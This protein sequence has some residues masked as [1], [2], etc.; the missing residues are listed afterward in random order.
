MMMPGRK[1]QAGSSS[2]R[3]GFNGQEKSNDVTQGNYTAEYWEY[4][5]RIGRRW[6]V[7]PKPNV[8]ISPYNCFEGNPI[9]FA[10]P[11]G[12]KPFDWI[13]KNNSQG[14]TEYKWDDKAKSPGTTPVGYTYVGATGSYANNNN[15]SVNLYANGGWF[16]SSGVTAESGSK[17][18][19]PPIQEAPSAASSAPLNVKPKPQATV[20]P[21]GYRFNND[22]ERGMI[23]DNIATQGSIML[24]GGVTA[25]VA[26]KL[27]INS[28][29][30][31]SVNGKNAD[32]ADVGINSLSPY[33]YGNIW[34]TSMVDWKPLSG[35]LTPK[36]GFINKGAAN[37]GLDLGINHIFYGLGK[38]PV[39]STPLSSTQKLVVGTV[40]S[41]NKTVIKKTF[42]DGMFPAQ[43]TY[44]VAESTKAPPLY[45]PKF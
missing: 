6:N 23:K 11:N 9:L 24:I 21:L 7:D 10:D 40:N 16:R 30:Q 41:V 3:Y 39:T 43:P 22:F 29:I 38:L 44:N 28:T 34:A 12:D 20:G 25:T 26:T 13:K 2:F 37:V 35:D 45:T 32:F 18:T 14:Q 5:S 8:A 31:L 15:S 17:G 42:N 36:V 4:D 19:A 33:T 1:Y 27:A